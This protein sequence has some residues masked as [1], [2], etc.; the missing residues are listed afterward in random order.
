[1][2][3]KGKSL[4]P[5]S[6]HKYDSQANSPQ[7]LE[8]SNAPAPSG[9]NK[10]PLELLQQ[11]LDIFKH[12]CRV[13]NNDKLFSTIQEVKQNLFN[14]D[15]SRA[16]GSEHF[17]EAYAARWSPSRALAYIHIF[18]HLPAVSASLLT[19]AP[20]AFE[21]LEQHKVLRCQQSGAK[22]AYIGEGEAA[23]LS[24]TA[25]TPTNQAKRKRIICFGAG[26]GAELVALAGY[27]KVL[28]GRGLANQTGV[29]GSQ[30]GSDESSC[31][32]F[33]VT[34]VDLADWSSITQKLISGIT[35][36][37][38]LS[39]YASQEAKA[40]SHPL[41]DPNGFS[42][43]FGQRDLLN[44]D[45]DD[46]AAVL[47][48]ATLVT[49][50][51][52]LNELYSTSMSQTTNLLLSLTYLLSPGALL[53]VVDSPGS[54]ST[55]NVGKSSTAG[56]GSNAEKNYPMQWLLDHTLLDAASLSSSKNSSGQNQQWEKI[57]SH[58]SKWFRLPDDLNYPIDLED[59]RYQLHLYRKL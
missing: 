51:F 38:V 34:L 21:G 9:F 57:E 27:L 20:E 43:E 14:R 24:T 39:Q 6:K 58:D 28:N 55:V 48:G 11:L 45:V 33:H 59:M 1:M 4:R 37:P 41:I 22:G 12:A 17:L 8:Q 31:K 30:V 47:N 50:M 5:S 49:L 2:P 56:D 40:A 7:S 32:S 19:Q 3:P 53:L 16:F 13:Q 54:Y 36:P 35:M 23:P 10:I 42:A 29:Q 25:L 26:G 15:F 44:V 46:M 18:C 52:T